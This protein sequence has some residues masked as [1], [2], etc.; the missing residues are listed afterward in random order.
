MGYCGIYGTDLELGLPPTCSLGS[1]SLL[2]PLA[3]AMPAPTHPGIAAMPVVASLAH[4]ASTPV[5]AV[6]ADSLPVIKGK[7]QWKWAKKRR[8]TGNIWGS[9]GRG[10]SPQTPWAGA[11]P[12]CSQWPPGAGHKP[13]GSYA[14]GLPDAIR[15]GR[16]DRAQCWSQ[17]PWIPGHCSH[18]GIVEA[19]PPYVYPPYAPP[20]ALTIRKSSQAW[21][22]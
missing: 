16:H 5:P 15:R 6:A 17:S 11:Q 21:W 7:R 4:A 9:A 22:Q 18:L 19:S 10:Y 3:S 12:S 13:A 1:G 20:S 14:V 8:E 2:G